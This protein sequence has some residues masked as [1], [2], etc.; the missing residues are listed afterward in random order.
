MK[1]PFRPCSSLWRQ[2]SVLLAAITVLA[3][4]SKSADV[5]PAGVSGR[6]P[7]SEPQSSESVAGT[8]KVDPKVQALLPITTQSLVA[9]VAAPEMEA[10]G[11]VLD[12]TT[13]AALVNDL[14][15]AEAALK[16]SEADEARLRRLLASDNASARTAQAAEAS[17]AHDRSSVQSARDRIALT[18]G[19]AVLEVA[20]PTWVQNLTTLKSAIVRFNLPPGESMAHPP[21][22]ARVV[23]IADETRSIDA[24]FLGFAPATDTQLQG[25]GLL[26]LIKI[27][28]LRVTP[29]AAV[30]G[31]LSQPGAAQRGVRVPRSAVIRHEA[32]S[33]VYVQRNATSFE[34][35]A[36]STSHA[37]EGGWLITAGLQAGDRVVTDGAQLLLSE[38][39]KS[40]TRVGD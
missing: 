8:V 3:A 13:L 19:T 24:H 12:P 4:C 10:A 40:Q 26:Y 1:A 27:N 35:V 20:Q 18:W 22:E 25:Q 21:A 16:A 5:E 37:V 29:D 9:V 11:R 30:I 14:T 39:L 33:W 7:S 23:Q 6:T 34:R 15:S 38:E 2:V 17:A 28:T 32:Q 36:A 31:Y